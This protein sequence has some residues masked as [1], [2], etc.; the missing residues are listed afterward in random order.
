MKRENISDIISD[1][2]DS[3]IEEAADVKQ[4]NKRIFRYMS[5]AACLALAV[6]AGVLLSRSG[7]VPSPTVGTQTTRESGMGDK[8]VPE[9]ATSPAIQYEEETEIAFIS[10]WDDRT[11]GEKYTSLM[12]NGVEYSTMNTVISEDYIGSFV[13]DSAVTGYDI[14]SD[15]TYSVASETYSIK[16]I[17]TDCAVAVKIGDENAYYVYVNVWYEPDT[18]GDF[19]TDLDLKNTVVFR[20]AYIDKYEYTKLSTEHTQRVYADFDDSVIWDML[21]DVSE[22]EN[23]EYNQPYDRISVETDLPVLGYKNISFAV[24]PDGYIITNILN[25]Q[26]CFFIGTQKYEA[27]AEYLEVNIPF[28]EY[29]T[30]YELNRDGAVP[31]KGEEVTT[32]PYIPE[33]TANVPSADT[34]QEKNNT[35]SKDIP[36]MPGGIVE[37]TTES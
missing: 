1:M 19:I 14:Y 32:P 23:T 10:Q 18:L 12:L 21:A 25:T 3:F 37:E 35:E 7:F 27:F 28:K 11:T 34:V 9:I 4:K 6:I 16:N 20:K 2:D 15:K 24:T 17:S 5:A 31:G 26:K 30:V 22:A 33:E 29:N 13:T 8:N 36:P